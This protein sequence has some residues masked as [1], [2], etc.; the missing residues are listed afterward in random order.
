[1]KNSIFRTG[2]VECLE[3]DASLPKIL[4][5]GHFAAAA[6]ALRR[7]IDEMDTD[8][9]SALGAND[10]RI[11]LITLGPRLAFRQA[12]DTNHALASAAI[13]GS[14]PGRGRSSTAAI[15]P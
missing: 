9:D 11:L 8:R 12:S 5:H 7:A 15:G 6:P 4:G 1:L 14:L 10:H 3:F 2:P 13:L